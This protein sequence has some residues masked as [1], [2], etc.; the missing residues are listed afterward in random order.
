M[1]ETQETTTPEVVNPETPD[2]QAPDT[3]TEA[4]TPEGGKVDAAPN[5][6][7]PAWVQKKIDKM[8]FKLREAQRVAEQLR[9]ENESLKGG[10]QEQQ[11]SRT[12]PVS[13]EKIREQ[14]R[15][16]EKMT[17]I[18]AQGLREIPTYTTAV[19]SLFAQFG[20]ELNNR[21]EFFETL[22][23]LP[24][25]HKVVH[26]LA[27]DPEAVASLLDK[28]PAQLAI[29]LAR[30]ADKVNKPATPKPISKAPAPAAPISSPGRTET[31][32]RPDMSMQEWVEM[33]K[34]RG[35]KYV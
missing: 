26:A 33:E 35:S 24:D 9:L 25:A 20:D 12:A 23:E 6:G 14:V 30:F 27:L 32:Y 21:Q 2:Q 19:S 29:G 11:E 1:S 17:Q 10:T 34:A 28:S 16:E 7:T 4:S 13:L 8:T 31:G 5:P 22:I 3:G 15:L 18:G